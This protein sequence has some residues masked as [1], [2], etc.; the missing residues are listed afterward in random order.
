[1]P[2][3]W[4]R[5]AFTISTDPARLDVAAVHAYLTTSYWARGISRELVQRS[6]DHA[7][8]FGLYRGAEQLGFARVITDRATFAYVADVFVLDAHQGHGLGTWLMETI[9]SHPDLQGLRRWVLLTR[10]RA[11]P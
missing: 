4:R 8:P 5:E 1:M 9:V 2:H 7:L 6:I 11:L 10:E 3:E